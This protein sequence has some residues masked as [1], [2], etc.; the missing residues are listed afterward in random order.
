[1]VK[2]MVKRSRQEFYQ[3][4]RALGLKGDTHKVDALFFWI[5]GVKKKP[6]LQQF[7]A[8]AKLY[9]G[10]YSMQMDDVE[11]IEMY[12]MF[13]VE[14]KHFL[15][16]RE[17][18]KVFAQAAFDNIKMLTEKQNPEQYEY[19]CGTSLEQFMEDMKALEG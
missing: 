1:M 6:T 4:Y 2:R 16:G 15:I 19:L 5:T 13:I 18:E 7:M 11:L 9:R 17:L 3:M 10:R 8:E 14:K 12:N